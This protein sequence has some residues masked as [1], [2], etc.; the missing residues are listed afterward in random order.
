MAEIEHFVDPDDKS[1]P[2]FNKVADYEMVLFSAC[3]QMDGTP[4]IN[5][6]MGDAVKQVLD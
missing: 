6:R 5:V 1:H 3:S 4:A 2:K